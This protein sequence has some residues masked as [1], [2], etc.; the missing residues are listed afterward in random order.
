MN[1]KFN[2]F[3]VFHVFN[4]F[5]GVQYR[6]HA[7]FAA[8]AHEWL[9]YSHSDRIRCEHLGNLVQQEGKGLV[10]SSSPLQYQSNATKDRKRGSPGSLEDSRLRLEALLCPWALP[11]FL[12]RLS[13][14]VG[15]TIK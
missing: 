15:S 9:V 12:V 2:V 1:A 10:A 8:H 13:M 7:G 11:A 14:I 3:H 6:G 4:A 5:N